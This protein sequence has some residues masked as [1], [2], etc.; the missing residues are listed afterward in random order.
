V[1]P[2]SSVTAADLERLAVRAHADLTKTLGTSV[3]PITIELHDTIE[4]FRVATGRPWWASAMVRDTSI[5]L[6]PAAVLVQRDGVDAA[7]RVA[8]AE[9][10][11]SQTL[12][13][14]PLWVR[15]GAGRY[16]GRSAAPAQPGSSPRARCPSDA[17]LTLAASVTAQREAERRAEACFARELARTHDWRTIR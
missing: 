12:A 15:V 17:E 11:V 2:T 4:S 5:D 9:L 7:L 10:L 14:R 16:F 6:A 3:A 13:G 1:P 8:V